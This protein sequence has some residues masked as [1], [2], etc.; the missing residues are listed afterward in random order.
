MRE[1]SLGGK[2]R[3][4]ATARAAAEVTATAEAAGGELVVIVVGVGD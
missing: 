4:K 2:V 1:Q 3:K